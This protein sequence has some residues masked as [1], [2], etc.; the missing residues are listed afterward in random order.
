MSSDQNGHRDEEVLMDIVQQQKIEGRIEGQIEATQENLVSID[1]TRFGSVPRNVR[2]AV[3][4]TRDHARLARWVEI[5]VV[6]S[7]AEI[8]TIVAKKTRTR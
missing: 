5:F 7:P 4:L 6:R 2:A 3:D 8:L 1:R